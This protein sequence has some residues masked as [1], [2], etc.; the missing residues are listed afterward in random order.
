[1]TI[2][3][4]NVKKIL[5]VRLVRTKNKYMRS[6]RSCYNE[7][8]TRKEGGGLIMCSQHSYYLQ[9]EKSFLHNEGDI[10]MG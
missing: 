2:S 6:L 8:K 4:V 5:L 1:M 10:G 9:V 7:I 3:N